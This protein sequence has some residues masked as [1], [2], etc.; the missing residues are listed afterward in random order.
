M[1]GHKSLVDRIKTELTMDE[2]VPHHTG[3]KPIRCPLPGHEDKHGS[4]MVYPDTNSFW[5]PS[6]P[7]PRCGGSPIDYLMLE[8]H[9]DFMGAVQHGAKRK[10][11]EMRPPT[12][13]EL[14]AEAA[15]HKR[16]ETLSALVRYAHGQLIADSEVAREAREYL[17]GRGFHEDLLR[18][19]QVGLVNLQKLYQVRGSHPLLAD[20]SQA[21]F[22]EAGLRTAKGGLLFRDTRIAFPL[23]NRQRAV[24]LTCRALPGSTDPRKFVH[25]AGQAAG[26]WNQDALFN[27]D[28][29]VT[30][31]E[32]VP[33]AATLVGFGI[34]AVGNLGLEVAKNAHLFAHLKVVTLVW[35]NDKAGRSRV[36]NAGR[37]IQAAL[38]DGEVRILH[39]P[40]E[41]DINDWAR[42]GG[43][44]EEFEQLKAKAPTLVEA[45]IAALPASAKSM[46]NED[47]Q[48]VFS[49][50]RMMPEISWEAYLGELASHI[51]VTLR[52]VER[53]F[54]VK[55]RTPAK[56]PS[57]PKPVEVSVQDGKPSAAYLPKQ[58]NH[59]RPGLDVTVADGHP[60]LSMG[61]I[62]QRRVDG[63]GDMDGVPAYVLT[64]ELLTVTATPDG[65]T[66]QM[67][68]YKPGVNPEQ[69]TGGFPDFQFPR[70]TDNPAR[71]RSLMAYLDDPAMTEPSHLL[72]QDIRAL[73]ADFA[74]LEDARELDLIAVWIMMTYVY[75]VFYTV[76]FL[77]LHGAKG[78][79]KTTILDLIDLL[80]FNSEKSANPTEASA[81]FHPHNT[82]GT[83]VTDE[84]ENLKNP[85]P[86]TREAL[87]LYIYIISYKKGAAQTK[88][89]AETKQSVVRYLYGPKCFG[90]INGLN[91][92]L[93]DRCITIHTH[94]VDTNLI[95][96]KD[97]QHEDAAL[98]AQAEDLRDR[99]HVWACT[100]FGE[101]FA[102]V[103][104]EMRDA[105]R[106]RLSNRQRELWLPPITIARAI[107]REA[108]SGHN[109]EETLLELEAVKRAEAQASEA[110][111]NP[112]HL[113]LR[114][115][116]QLLDDRAMDL[117]A[118]N[119]GGHHPG[120]YSLSVLVAEIE[121]VLHTQRSLP[122]YVQRDAKWLRSLLVDEHVV[123][124]RQKVQLRVSRDGQPSAREYCYRI[125]QD[126]L[127]AV[128]KRLNLTDH[129]GEDD[130]SYLVAPFVAPV[131]R[132]AQ[133]GRVA[134]RFDLGDA[135][136]F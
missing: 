111:E 17:A 35:D 73:L 50:I 110:E 100:H 66:V 81:S 105:H 133:T 31:G 42:A 57:R 104:G 63:E 128:L 116:A 71:R 78:T 44:R 131:G 34:P 41:K 65:P 15:R 95:Q 20:F 12:E 13:E 32:G 23:L 11:W 118:S 4:F 125:D 67:V 119:A 54:H 33:D 109:L 117:C 75:A 5:C 114:M 134:M 51:Q 82:G 76:C 102:M 26:L 130:G 135:V 83:T 53:L 21:D 106:P 30:V 18:E 129:D 45:M 61:M 52:K 80:A 108:G 107:D 6:H 22:E 86:G 8:Q 36:V 56:E 84:T 37:A 124:P 72:F 70:W 1:N 24:G 92:V 64:R 127:A 112:R 132:P 113:Y 97:R 10:G 93:N 55:E 29:V 101:L 59:L 123:D 28:R 49:A 69:D 89:N 94:L 77:H 58:A 7:G 60:R 79:G 2:L 74:H 136:P 38:R 68:T 120:M 47:L 99:L 96:L 43:T 14:V 121:K 85:R 9:T 122:L 88:G 91:H 25:L 46:R 103:T 48:S 16:E 90:S 19:H 115:L 3:R 40:G 87:V 39:M 62:M 98:R 27:K 126:V